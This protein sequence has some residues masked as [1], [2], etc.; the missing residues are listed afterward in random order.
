[1]RLPASDLGTIAARTEHA[2]TVEPG[3]Y[4]QPCLGLP[5]IAIISPARYFGAQ[6]LAGLASLL[7]LLFAEGVR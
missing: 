4:W 3:L 2:V 7:T 1:M 5:P 6:L